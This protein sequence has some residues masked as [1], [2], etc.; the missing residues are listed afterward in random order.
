MLAVAST[1]RYDAFELV[2]KHSL[3]I[4]A[5]ADEV[6]AHGVAGGTCVMDVHTIACAAY[7]HIAL[8]GL[9]AADDV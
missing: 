6:A 8:A 1:L 4:G 5:H 2:G 9:V 7:N 3:A